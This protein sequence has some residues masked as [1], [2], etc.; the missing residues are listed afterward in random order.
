MNMKA[1]QGSWEIIETEMW[2]KEALDLTETAYIHFNGDTGNFH[3][4]CIDG[5]MDVEYKEERAEF[6]WFGN[7]ENDTASGHGWVVVDDDKLR[8]K[9]YFHN[10]D[11]TTFIATKM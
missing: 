11:D 4:I 2:D 5:Q 1:F 10:S 6:T 9:I 3:L 7:D 8:G